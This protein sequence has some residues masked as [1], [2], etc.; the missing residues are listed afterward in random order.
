VARPVRAARDDDAVTI[1][2]LVVT[3]ASG[4]CIHHPLHRVMSAHVVTPFKQ[5][6]LKLVAPSSCN[7]Q[8]HWRT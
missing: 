8:I 2:L 1:V 4:S 3:L 7:Q 5:F 6:L